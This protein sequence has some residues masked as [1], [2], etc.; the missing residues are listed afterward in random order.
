MNPEHAKMDADADKR[1]RCVPAD[2]DRAEAGVRTRLKG[3]QALG[4]GQPSLGAGAGPRPGAYHQ[5]RGDP[6]EPTRLREAK[7]TESF[8]GWVLRPAD[9]FVDYV[10]RVNGDGGQVLRFN[11]FRSA[12]SPRC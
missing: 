9:A 8:R 2:V 4:R 5:D 10:K 1:R 7:L 3:A 6:D 12:P 11:A